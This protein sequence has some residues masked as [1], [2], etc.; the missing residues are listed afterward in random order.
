[1][2]G[3]LISFSLLICSI[4]NYK[5]AKRYFSD[6]EEY[7]GLLL[8]VIVFAVFGARLYHIVGELDFYIKNP[9]H[10][11]FI[12]KGGLGI[13]GAVLAGTIPI[14]MHFKDKMRHLLWGFLDTVFIVLPLGQAIGRWG[15][16]FNYELIGLPT[17]VP[18]A[19]FVPLGFRPIAY[20]NNDTFHPIFLYESVMTFLLFLVLL[21]LYRRKLGFILDKPR[22][23]QAGLF[24]TYYSI[25]YGLIRFFLE[26]L[27]IDKWILY[28]INMNQAV[29][30]LVIIFGIYFFYKKKKRASGLA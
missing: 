7:F 9:M 4:I 18:W 8:K 17:H 12:H 10:I 21:F 26:F 19:M 20:I 5:L 6:S 22:V 14:I 27:R 11:L 23:S 25:G 29:S 13:Y 24:I 1:M 3:L 2:Y 15:N 16:Y 30:L 28:G